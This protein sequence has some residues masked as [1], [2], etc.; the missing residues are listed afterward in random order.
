MC[1]FDSG[2]TTAFKDNFSVLHCFIFYHM[3]NEIEKLTKS[4][5][6]IIAGDKHK[7]IGIDMR[8]PKAS[9]PC[10]EIWKN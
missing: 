4:T 7:A 9:D 3:V 6:S 2:L 10:E 8:R 1:L 5:R